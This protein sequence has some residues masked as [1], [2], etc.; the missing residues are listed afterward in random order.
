MTLNVPKFG[1][2]DFAA[3]I[4]KYYYEK[5]CQEMSIRKHA[6]DDFIY[7]RMTLL[8]AL[9]LILQGHSPTFTSSISPTSSAE[10]TDLKTLWQ[11]VKKL[12]CNSFPG[13]V[14]NA[15]LLVQCPLG[16][17]LLGGIHQDLS[18]GH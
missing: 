15:I 7:R 5:T 16:C 18:Q 10:N 8:S 6:F 2:S 11:I 9:T 13:Q 3:S 12:K 4:G 14:L 17:S 1:N